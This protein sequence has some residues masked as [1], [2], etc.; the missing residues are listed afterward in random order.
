M[1]V[2]SEPKS[3]L[4][5]AFEALAARLDQEIRLDKVKLK[6]AVRRMKANQAV[7]ESLRKP[8]P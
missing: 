4:E 7:L 5:I 8:S 1:T 6:L 2:A 3:D